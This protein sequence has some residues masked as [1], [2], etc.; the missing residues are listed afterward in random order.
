MKEGDDVLMGSKV[1]RFL[2]SK[3][4]VLI[5][6]LGVWMAGS[7]V[8]QANGSIKDY[9]FGMVYQYYLLYNKAD[10]VQGDAA[11][12]KVLS[13][14]NLGS[15]GVSGEFS[16]DDIVNGVKSSGDKRIAES[17]SSMMATYSTYGYMTNKVQGF[18]A[19]LPMTGRV[20]SMILLVP[21]GIL[22]DV[23][24]SIVPMIIKLIAKLNVI[25]LL[26][27]MYGNSAQG[28]KILSTLKISKSTFTSMVNVIATAALVMIL[29]TL[30]MM[31]RHGTS[32]IDRRYSSKLAGRLMSLIGI[33]LVVIGSASLITDLTQLTPAK[34]E[35]SAGFDRYMVD[36]RSW[37][38]NVNFAPDGTDAS[39][40]SDIKKGDG[41]YVDL[42]FN[43][44]K[45]EGTN[46]IKSINSKSSLAGDESKFS[47]TSLALA[48]GT[49]QSFSA[50]DYIDYKGSADSQHFYGSSKGTDSASS[51]NPG[52]ANVYGS[53]YQY[54]QQLG[55]T[56]VK[57]DDKSPN[58]TG[59]T[60][61]D[62]G[63]FLKSHQQ[64][65]DS[66]FKSAL[67]DY[68]DDK[69]NLTTSAAMAW[70]DRFIYGA[71]SAG[72][73][74][75][76]YY[77]ETPGWEM[78]MSGVG[79][80]GGYALSDQSMFLVLS[81]IFNETGGRYYIDAPARGIE[82]ATAKFD[83]NR[84]T[85]YVVSMVG[86]PIFTLVG[87]LSEPIIEL[88]VLLAV[89]TAVMSLGLIE[90][91]ARP[92]R[93]WLKGI[94]L[95]DIEYTQAFLIYAVGIAGTV[96]MFQAVPQFIILMITWAG[97]LIGSPL[98]S[99]TPSSAW[100]SLA[101]NGLPLIFQSFI[102]IAFAYLYLKSKTFREKL[103]DLFTLP[104]EWA[105]TTGDR[106]ERQASPQGYQ[107]AENMKQA[108]DKNVINSSLNAS[109]KQG[110]GIGQTIADLA[111]DV[112]NDI[113]PGNKKG[114]LTPQQRMALAEDSSNPLGN[115]V[116]Q[117]NDINKIK[118]DG[119]IGRAKEQTEKLVDDNV[120]P[121]AQAMA[122]QA[123]KA[124][125]T[126]KETP[127]KVHLV[128]AEKNLDDLRDK[129]VRD[130]ASPE[131]VE[132]V[133]KALQELH[134]L[135]KTYGVA[136]KDIDNPNADPNNPNVDPNANP[137]NPNANPNADPNN[138]DET[139]DGVKPLDANDDGAL[140]SVHGANPKKDV[141]DVTDQ[142]SDG[143]AASN[144]VAGNASGNN[145]DGLVNGNGLSDAKLNDVKIENSQIIQPKASDKTA[146][147]INL[148][149]LVNGLKGSVDA[150]L[151]GD[152][153]RAKLDP[154]STIKGMTSGM[155]NGGINVNRPLTGMGTSTPNLSNT[156]NN[157]RPIGGTVNNGSSAAQNRPQ[158]INRVSQADKGIQASN[159]TQAKNST[160]TN[161]GPTK[162][163]DVKARAGRN[164]EGGRPQRVEKVVKNVTNNNVDNRKQTSNVDR[165]TH[166][167][168]K[169]VTNK[170]LSKNN[171]NHINNNTTL[172]NRNISNTQQHLQNINQ[173]KRSLGSAGNRQ[174]F[175]QILQHMKHA[176]TKQDMRSDINHLH[177]AIKGLNGSDKNMINKEKTTETL[178]NM[179][180]SLGKVDKP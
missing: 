8:T 150:K 20:L 119:V 97:K 5:A 26:A 136:N 117:P 58:L 71:K 135:D 49:L 141:A 115:K 126:F 25:N 137:N 41:T 179:I 140:D 129:M 134:G 28:A 128:S 16:Y 121:D 73:S 22:L 154:N 171:T 169:N 21:L 55:N 33:P 57:I 74:L 156:S 177:Q 166:H 1:K 159:G 132:S 130:G 90:M 174:E 42:D 45:T 54:A 78:V 100:G 14:G 113:R 7:A 64:P 62:G 110:S 111:K 27:E 144:G 164:A 142:S 155:P 43:P 138:P 51:A 93:A 4:I 46:R 96:L 40:K 18:E 37:A 39:N 65:N 160:Q 6:I 95:G 127:D 152:D 104:W 98:T 112:G 148:N 82:Q 86:S 139:Q 173:L 158:T 30:A 124:L 99:E 48:Y 125:D 23:L 108:R 180:K 10:E 34:K 175:D 105:I 157:N 131:Q 106:L 133:D 17:F 80:N 69:N 145:S 151:T 76:K 162:L 75:D 67:D 38:Y 85:Y 91:N 60:G 68:K 11:K 77:G 63:V 35:I 70:R 88:V 3:F 36:D 167:A 101:V 89:V 32:R 66:P 31:M 163:D 52:D 92:L 79:T 84:S 122:G 161:N 44:Y 153:V 178:R 176:N 2:K 15:G 149:N 50:V 9:Q 13:V 81:T 116:A 53:Y 83:S 165:S 107:L 123:D 120:N 102:A 147:P 61:S 56:L 114:Y 172:N 168:N 47:N 94:T 118:R 109:K 143:V 72:N 87:M 29:I 59:S 170:N 103:I 12:Q 146:A 19:L 24:G